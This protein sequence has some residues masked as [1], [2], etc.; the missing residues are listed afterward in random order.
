MSTKTTFKRVALVAVAAL[1]LGVLSVAPSSAVV[2]GLTVTG[3]NGTSTLSASGYVSDSTT[4]ATVTVSGLL[5][6]SLDSV[7]VSFVEKSI[8]ALAVSS[9]SK[10]FLYLLDTTTPAAS[11][12]VVE[13]ASSV[14]ALVGGAAT[15]ATTWK[16]AGDTTTGIAAGTTVVR[17]ISSAST[18]Y[19]GAKFGIQLDSTTTRIAGT[20][21]YTVIVK[22]YTA[23]ATNLTVPAQTITQDVSIVID[24]DPAAAALVNGTIA[25]ALST[26]YINAGSSYTT[27][28]D[29]SVAVVATASSTDIATIRVKTY[30]VDSNPAPESVTA[31]VTGPGLVC[32]TV[33]AVTTCGKSI[34][35]LGTNGSNDFTVRADGNAGVSSI[36]I[37]T[38]SKT[39]AAKTVTF[40]AKA[41]KTITLAVN[42]PVIGVGS[43]SDVIR[44]SAVDADGNVW[45]GAAYIV[46][47]TAADALIAGSATTPVACTFDTT[48][49]FHACP[50]SGTYVGT[51]NFKVIDASTVALATAT[52]STAAVTVSAGTPTSVK[53]AF[54]KATYGPGEKAVVTVSVVDADGKAVPAQTVTNAFTATGITSN[55]ALGSQ[56]DA[57]TSA[58]VVV[59]GATSAALKTTAGAQQYTV[60]MP[61]ASGDVVLTATGST[62]LA[63]AGR[64]AVTA[65]ASVVNASV[66]AATDAAN[67]ATDAANAATDAAL[68]AADAADAAT[69]AAQDASDAV[70]ALS[71]TVAKLVASLKAQITSLTNLV[72]KIQKKVR[73]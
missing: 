24:K 6:T 59:E 66:D 7:T 3:A 58:N 21:T 37:A 63:L 27:A 61:Q 49:K 57:L 50:V 52:S 17:R 48:Y 34:K 30:T 65:T 1:G 39:F 70:A 46:A 60:Y 23:G 26:A 55:V 33:S 67:E 68:A 44:A 53:I 9:T 16:A 15:G 4:A 73:A 14:V 38:T 72:I 71:A 62:G 45:G 41:A 22:A 51:A 12:T 25:P 40:Y 2:S 8:P 29:S 31:S 28:S 18:G 69:A 36:V 11:S 56:S 13:T 64:V 35:I 47:A 5:D 32:N 20:Y 43:S 54:D 19:V 10:A 42:K